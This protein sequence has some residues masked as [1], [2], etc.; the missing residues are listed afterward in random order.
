VIPFKRIEYAVYFFLEGGVNIVDQWFWNQENPDVERAALHGLLDIYKSGGLGCIAA[1]ILDFGDG[2]YGLK[3][4]RRGG[5][6][7]CPIFV[8]G[9][10]DEKTEIT[11]L[12][13]ARWDDSKKRLRPFGA[14]GTAEENL[15]V[16]RENPAR[17]R[18]G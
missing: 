16:L 18:R 15:E 13:G 8:R 10:F 1:S 11:F 5:V 17:R 6:L 12:A 9:P 7:P 3:V 4:V 2:F 14:V